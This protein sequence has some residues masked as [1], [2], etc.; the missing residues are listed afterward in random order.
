MTKWPVHTKN[1]EQHTQKTRTTSRRNIR[2]DKKNTIF[3]VFRNF[4]FCFFYFIFLKLFIQEILSYRLGTVND[5]YWGFKPV[6]SFS[7][8]HSFSTFWWRR[9]WKK[10][11]IYALQPGHFEAE[12]NDRKV[13]SK[14]QIK[15][16]KKEKP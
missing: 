7:K 9:K 8:P 12:Q 10:M 3:C 4:L 1:T 13:K 5:F 2:S 14:I 6:L 11:C 15:G 16:V